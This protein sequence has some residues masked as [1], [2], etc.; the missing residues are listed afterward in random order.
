[1]VKLRKESIRTSSPAV[2]DESVTNPSKSVALSGSGDS[3]GE[4]AAGVV[5]AFLGASTTAVDASGGLGV[6]SA[7]ASTLS[8]TMIG[9]SEMNDAH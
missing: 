5:A 4:G 7:I 8:S 3:S 6:E 1:M 9:D 2:T